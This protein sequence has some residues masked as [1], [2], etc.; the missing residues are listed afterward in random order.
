M[1]VENINFVIIDTKSDE[2]GRAYEYLKQFIIKDNRTS[3]LVMMDMY[4]RMNTEASTFCNC[5]GIIA[6]A[7]GK[8]VGMAVGSYYGIS[9][10][11]DIQFIY[12]IP[13]YRRLG[14]GKKMA[15][16]LV[17]LISADIAKPYT[18]K[19]IFARAFAKNEDEIAKKFGYD[20]YS[21][22]SN[23]GAGVDG[24]DSA[25][26]TFFIRNMSLDKPISTSLI[27]GFCLDIILFDH[28]TNPKIKEVV[29]AAINKSFE[30]VEVC[31][32]DIVEDAA[33]FE[34]QR[35]VGILTSENTE[36]TETTEK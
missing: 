6:L 1:H 34:D 28:K 5:K 11:M 24:K 10:T 7:D 35:D 31:D 36:D 27:R 9:M 26:L 16:H 29:L 20:Y 4:K 19:A 2:H 15:D 25:N 32:G 13:K 23:S 14:L 3:E 17:E 33:Y 12:V 18:V 22:Y 21:L 8:P 30:S